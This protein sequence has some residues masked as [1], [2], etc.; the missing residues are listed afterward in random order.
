[1][2][3][4]AA[5]LRSRRP[6]PPSVEVDHRSSVRLPQPADAAGRWLPADISVSE[7]MTKILGL[8][9]N[10]SGVVGFAS[11]FETVLARMLDG[12]CRAAGC[13]LRF[14]GGLLA[15]PGSF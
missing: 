7:L 8:T 14:L 1:M 12:G 9:I 5:A 6:V 2:P 13:G 10:M 3:A 15:R 11:C 4:A